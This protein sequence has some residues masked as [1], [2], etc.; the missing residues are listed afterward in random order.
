MLALAWIGML[1]QRRAVKAGKP[2]SI[3]REMAGHPIDDH[4]DVVLVAVI[5]EKLEVVRRAETRR[6]R[7]VAGH[8]IAPRA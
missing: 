6:W 2:V 8:L 3:F 1:V 5:D 4:A 7:I